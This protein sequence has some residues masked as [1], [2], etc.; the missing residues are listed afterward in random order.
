MRAVTRACARHDDPNSKEHARDAA[1][2]KV[3]DKT[4]WEPKAA[5]ERER[6]EVERFA[7]PTK[8][9][10]FQMLKGEARIVDGPTYSAHAENLNEEL[11]SYLR[12][13]AKRGKSAKAGEKVID[14]N[15]HP[16][17][18]LWS[19][20]QTIAPWQVPSVSRIGQSERDDLFLRIAEVCAK[21]VADRDCAEL[22]GGGV[23]FD[24]DGHPHAHL[25]LRR[26]RRNGFGFG[27]K[28]FY[29]RKWDCPAWRIHRR[30]PGLLSKDKVKMLEENLAE[31][32]SRGVVMNQYFDVAMD[33]AVDVAIEQWIKE[34]GPVAWKQYQR[35]IETYVK[36][37][38]ADEVRHRREKLDRSRTV[39][40]DD[41]GIWRTFLE[42]GRWEASKFAIRKAVGLL[43]PPLQPLGYRIIKAAR[44]KQR[45]QKLL[46]MP[47]LSEMADMV[48]AQEITPLQKISMK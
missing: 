13:R 18:G 43:P 24:R 40:E 16:N 35:D 38:G 14:K 17:G 9:Y 12:Y 19:H 30:F 6:I 25:H 36:L 5:P 3:R 45:L 4:L 42:T 7:Y 1:A 48:T 41:L 23:H 20:V 21:T 27:K 44:S 47:R 31:A 22:E 11:R 33:A 46:A 37:K 29:F 2:K 10:C 32:E 28:N 39:T 8:G 15:A 34:K 26:T